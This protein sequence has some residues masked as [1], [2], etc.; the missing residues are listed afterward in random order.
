MTVELTFEG[1]GFQTQGNGGPKCCSWREKQGEKDRGQGSREQVWV[2]REAWKL[3]G[4]TSLCP[5]STDSA[6]G[7]CPPIP[8]E[9]W[10]TPSL[11]PQP[12]AQTP[13]FSL[14]QI[15]MNSLRT[16]LPN[17]AS[18]WTGVGIYSLAGR[19]DSPTGSNQKTEQ[20]NAQ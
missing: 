3:E 6:Q 5:G 4:R 18:P 1:F 19:R 20:D 10:Y 15:S 9:G 13:I 17:T 14:I 8:Q 16:T 11:S 12:T 2:Q 7:G